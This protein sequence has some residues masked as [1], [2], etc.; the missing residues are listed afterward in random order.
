MK[1]YA[2]EF[3]GTFVLVATVGLTV[4]CNMN[5][6]PLAIGSALMV[7]VYAGGHVSG[8]HYNPAVTIAVFL[9]GKCPAS[10]VPGYILAQ[11]VGAACAAMICPYLKNYP[12]VA[13][14]EIE[15]MRAL[16]AE[17]IFTFVLAYVV[18][19]VATARK[20]AGNSYYGLA[21]GFA[22]LVGAVAIGTVSGAAL[23]PAVAIGAT[24]MGLL[25]STN[26]WVYL[27]A[28]LAAAASAAAVFKFTDEGDAG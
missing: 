4:M 13:A 2:V 11:I 16:L 3:L 18:L 9:R 5:W 26:L 19:N 8:A 25:K 24:M 7:M 12:E 15:P 21:I 27:V 1:K 23:N 10:D 6:A 20:T 22:V 14:L 28:T 17:F